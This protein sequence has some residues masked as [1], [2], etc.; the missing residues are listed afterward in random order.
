MLIL[1][2][3]RELFG[4]QGMA[5]R[6]NWIPIGLWC[7]LSGTLAC[8]SHLASPVQEES[9]SVSILNRSSVGMES[10]RVWTQLVNDEA[11]VENSMGCN[12]LR[13]DP[14][15]STQIR[16]T[17]L[18]LHSSGA[19]PQGL[20]RMASRLANKG[21]RAYLPA[22][23]QIKSDQWTQVAGASRHGAEMEDFLQPDQFLAQM[24]G[25]LQSEPGMKL[26]AGFGTGATA[27]AALVTR[28]GGQLD[29]LLL[30][31]PGGELSDVRGIAP[32]IYS[33]LSAHIQR[34]HLTTQI[35]GIERD[36][37]VSRHLLMKKMQIEKPAEGQGVCY[38]PEYLA[39]DLG[40]WE[41][42]SLD[43]ADLE[44]FRELEEHS[45]DFLDSGSFFPQLNVALRHVVFFGVRLCALSP[46][47]GSSPAFSFRSNP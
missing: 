9:Q 41:R 23:P 36:L 32:E 34:A 21:W 29:R 30:V 26:V 47:K 4:G 28:G 38:L 18:F 12:S 3:L 2:L 22:V 25:L 1:T 5:R 14:D 10:D 24:N 39:S 46:L 17:V 31:R 27:A 6:K 45:I 44:K 11:K 33:D 16:G 43:P 15:P 7:L 13:F 40:E 19:C 37:T 35:V 42:F 8:K 20:A